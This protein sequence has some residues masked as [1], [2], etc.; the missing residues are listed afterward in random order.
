MN[1]QGFFGFVSL[2]FTVSGILEFLLAEK[3]RL[4]LAPFMI[5]W[6]TPIPET[7]TNAKNTKYIIGYGIAAKIYTKKYENIFPFYPTYIQ[8]FFH[9]NL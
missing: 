4:T 6:Q 8:Y 2:L 3:G 9:L 7:N 5:L 1:K